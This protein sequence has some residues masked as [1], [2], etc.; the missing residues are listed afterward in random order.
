MI[1][2]PIEV[3]PTRRWPGFAAIVWI[4]AHVYSVFFGK[5]A[6]DVTEDARQY[7]A[8]IGGKGVEL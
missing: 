5:S 6:E 7:L 2:Q 1:H 8:A 4:H 3:F